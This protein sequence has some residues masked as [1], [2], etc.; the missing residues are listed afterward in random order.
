MTGRA[1][2]TLRRVTATPSPGYTARGWG[3]SRGAFSVINGTCRSARLRDQPAQFGDGCVDLAALG[4]NEVEQLGRL[5]WD[6]EGAALVICI[7]QLEDMYLA[8]EAEV[9]FQRAMS[10]VC[11]L[12]DRIPSSIVVIS[13]LE[14]YFDKLRN[15]LSASLRDRIERSLALVRDTH[16]A[17]CALLYI[18]VDRFKVINDSL[19]HLAGD[20]VLKEVAHRLQSCVREPDVV[21]RLS[22]DEFAIL[23]DRVDGPDTA[24]AVANRVLQA[25]GQPLPVAG[26]ELQPSASLG[27]GT[28]KY[29]RATADG[30]WQ[31]NDT[32]AFRLNVMGASGDMPA[33]TLCAIEPPWE[34]AS[35]WTRAPTTSASR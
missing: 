21:A 34:C 30:N 6:V 32:S 2:V 29:F 3:R 22:G 27:I 20:A 5:I 28:D 7:D 13:C 8:D 11:E 26:R 14:D 16:G 9:R 4:V 31:F 35:T 12:A 33:R 19:G 1:A 18:D 10:T 23:L 15:H 17:R 24:T 25:L